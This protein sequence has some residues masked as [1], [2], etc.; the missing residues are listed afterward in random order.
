M[1]PGSLNGGC[2]DGSD[3]SPVY[4]YFYLKSTSSVGSGM[5][6]SFSFR[7]F[8]FAGHLNVTPNILATTKVLSVP[9]EARSFDC[10]PSEI[11]QPNDPASPTYSVSANGDIA[12]Q[13]SNNNDLDV[14]WVFTDR[15][16]L[17]VV[18]VDAFPGEIVTLGGLAWSFQFPNGIVCNNTQ[19]IT[20]CNPN[21]P[22]GKQVAVPPICGF[23]LLLRFG[24]PINDPVPGHPARKKVPVIVTSNDNTP[25]VYN[26]DALDFLL[27]M[28]ATQPMGSYLIEGAKILK[29]DIMFYDETSNL[30]KRIYAKARGLQ[31]AA[32]TS[33]VPAIGNTLFYI[34]MDGPELESDCS[35]VNLI[36]TP[37]RRMA[38]SGACCQPRTGNN[39]EVTW[40][41]GNCPYY[42]SRTT[43]SI[44]EA[45]NFLPPAVYCSDI[46]LDVLIGTT[47][48]PTTYNEVNFS[49]IIEH[50]G[51]LTWNSTKSQSNYCSNMPFCVSTTAMP[52]GQLRLDFSIDGTTPVIISP[53]LG[54]VQLARLAFTGTNCCISAVTFVDG[55]LQASGTPKYCLPSTV[56][57]ILK[58]SNADDVCSKSLVMK[59]TVYD[60]TE[61]KD[62][63]YTASNGGVCSVPGNA[64]AYGSESICP[65][66]L[67]GP[68][69]LTPTKDDNPLNGVTT[70]DL[71]LIS[72]HL[73]GI[74]SLN[75]PYRLIAADANISNSI[76]TFDIVEFRKLILG[77][78]QKL[79]G[80]TSWRFVPKSH[81][82]PNPQNP[83]QAPF[84]E[85]ANFTVPPDD[86]TIEF[87]GIKVG[88][89]NQTVA[90]RPV[91]DIPST[92]SISYGLTGGSSGD[93][94]EVPIFARQDMEQ[95]AWQM[96]LR[97]DVSKAKLI[98]LE[99]ATA[100]GEYQAQDWYEPV[101]GTVNALW[102]DGEGKAAQTETGAP[103]FYL[104]LELLSDISNLEIA[105]SRDTAQNIAYSV[106]G[107]ETPLMLEPAAMSELRAAPA[108]AK[109]PKAAAWEAGVYPNPASG[110]FRFELQLPEAAIIQVSIFDLLGRQVWQST[111]TMAAG[112]NSIAPE[113]GTVLAAG[114]YFVQFESPFGRKTLRFVKM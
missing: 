95:A 100:A 28:S 86:Q 69:T 21:G 41:A 18:A 35:T 38:L 74:E 17:F 99:W 98:G 43:L 50:S 79:P 80:N 6:V 2:T 36:F 54:P 62:I 102:Y 11:N 48:A 32:S 3:C 65:C 93:I 45:N 59:Y 88:D 61:M 60:G 53:Q 67:P 56:S 111:A 31:V 85:E 78:Y 109:L 20:Y 66:A 110:H 52:T 34:V 94:I 5:P 82:F 104:K 105:L 96:S 70:Y 63:E 16:L 1:P 68:Q 13:V 49:I 47:F 19:L 64:V 90:T 71:V 14:N 22:V 76:T 44:A 57:S 114:Q 8:N 26:I 39:S 106:E 40:N 55:L 23:P 112:Y 75:S 9:N 33:T 97:Y 24:A 58:A 42:C 25:V 89:V 73:L 108:A 107:L 51:T 113:E 101:P 10:S 77:I 87:Y 103:L 27:R 37:Y 81:T 12:Y 46:L 72:K 92:R 30:D 84:P 29:S 4:F 83:F 91:G 7:H 15:K